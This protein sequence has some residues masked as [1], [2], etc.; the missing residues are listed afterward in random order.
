MDKIVIDTS[1]C[2]GCGKCVKDCVASAL[3]LE[4]KKAKLREGCIECGH[5]F[6]ICPTGAVDMPEYDKEGCVEVTSMTDID[7]DILL[8]AMKSRRTIRQ[9]KNTPV[10][11]EKIDKILEA[12]RYA[13]TGSNSQNV[14]FTIL[15]SKKEQ[16]EKEC[17]KLF[18][19]GVGIGS[20]FSA[21]LKNTNINDT[22]FFK[23]APLVIVVSA[24][25]TVNGT[26]ASA[27]MEIMANS[28]GLGVL[29]SGFFCACTKINPK[30]KAMLSLP[31]GHKAV[32]CMIIGYPDVEYQRIA[33][34][35]QHEIKKL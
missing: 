16:L 5:C 3:F 17:V 27:Y 11:Q 20:K 29:Y 35:K 14:A 12:G 33:P 25:N 7:S 8:Q 13:P 24:H 34:R 10:E 6:A 2:V 22:F 9:Y 23:G 31:K 30:I 21:S 1:K 4:N 15:G 28:L 18:R 26:L 19:T 32:T